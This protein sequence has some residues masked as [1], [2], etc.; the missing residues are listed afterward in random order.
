MEGMDEM[1]E[2]PGN[3]FNDE[4]QLLFSATMKGLKRLNEL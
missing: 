3:D 1:L 2:R 4:C